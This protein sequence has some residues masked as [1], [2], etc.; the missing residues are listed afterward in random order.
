MSELLVQIERN[1]PDFVCIASFPPGGLTHATYTCKRLREAFPTMPILVGRWGP[2]HRSKIERDRLQR[3][4]ATFVT[5]T[6]RETCG[7]L[8]THWSALSNVTGQLFMNR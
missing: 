1:P 2:K 4:G 7:I 5:T 3:A 8:E 6:L